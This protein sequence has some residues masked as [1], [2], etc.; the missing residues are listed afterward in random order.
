[1]RLLIIGSLSGQI[2]AASKI[3]MARGAKVGHAAD[4]E[5]AL[6]GLY[7]ALAPQVGRR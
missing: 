1:M 4:I 3:A 7:M 6:L 2:G 5:A